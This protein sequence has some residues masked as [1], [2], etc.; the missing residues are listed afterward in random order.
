[1]AEVLIS[2]KKYYQ[3][4]FFPV[5]AKFQ[6]KEK[7]GSELIHSAKELRQVRAELIIRENAGECKFLGY[8]K[9]DQ[10]V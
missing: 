9:P 7:L 6:G 1:M 10:E 5:V 3:L 4:T 8:Y 2:D